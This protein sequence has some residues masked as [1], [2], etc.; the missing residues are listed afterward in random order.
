MLSIFKSTLGGIMLNNR[1]FRKGLVICL[2][3]LLIGISVSASQGEHKE[4]IPSYDCMNILN[5]PFTK[6]EI[7]ALQRQSKL[8]RWSFT[9]GETSA[10]KRSIDELCGLDE[11]EEWWVNADFDQIVPM[12]TLPSKFDWR[13]EV[14]GGLPPIKDQGKC[15]SCW[16]FATVGPLECNIKIRDKITVDLSEQWLVSCNQETV[17][18]PWG[19]GGGWWAHDYFLNSG[20]KD[21]CGDSGAVFESN[22]PYKAR[23]EP[24]I[25]PYQHDYYIEKCAYVG[26]KNAVPSV[27][28]IKQA[29][30]DYG[31][32]TAAVCAGGYF[33]IYTGG[34]FDI[35]S[36]C[37]PKDVNHGVVLVGWDDNQ[38]KNGVWFLRNSWGED[39][40]ED[41]YMRIEYGCSKIGYGARYIEYSDRLTV[42]CVNESSN[43]GPGSTN[44]YYGIPNARVNVKSLD[45]TI[46]ETGW[47]NKDGRCYF[48][49]LPE[50]TDYII[51]VNHSKW[52]QIKV[53]WKSENFVIVFMGS[54]I[55]RIRIAQ[56]EFL[57]HFPILKILIKNLIKLSS[58]TN[59]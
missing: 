43:Q 2:V 29:I 57:R 37:W 23:D 52:K 22:F 33:M 30:F 53:D 6:E 5:K 7:S 32:V 56:F 19:C 26:I 25:C 9:V 44:K 47:T 27:D 50:N 51:K 24:C 34:I 31:P 39:W 1:N 12:D 10:S 42:F 15:G 18:K 58:I 17:P 21:P 46:D 49:D 4:Q 41:G 13:D 3:V 55:S 14:E 45:G 36:N 48:Y 8:E 38:G 28:N 59:Q 16:A 11:P 20:K 54:E 35:E 40:G